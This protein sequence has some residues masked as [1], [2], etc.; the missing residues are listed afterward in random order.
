MQTP[1]YISIRPRNKTSCA[2]ELGE[3]QYNGSIYSQNPNKYIQYTVYIVYTMY[4]IQCIFY[5]CWDFI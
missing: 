1:S 3:P 5:I 2:C 4:N